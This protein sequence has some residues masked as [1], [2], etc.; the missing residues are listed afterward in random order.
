MSWSK[1][2]CRPAYFTIVEGSSGV[3]ILAYE[4]STFLY[5]YCLLPVYNQ[6]VQAC[7]SSAD[8]RS[9]RPLA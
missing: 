8:V 5:D 6:A 1:L 4:N 7:V 3:G 2:V 9:P